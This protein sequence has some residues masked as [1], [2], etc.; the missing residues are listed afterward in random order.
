MVVKCGAIV[1]VDVALVIVV[2]VAVV[3]VVTVD[4]KLFGKVFGQPKKISCAE[5]VD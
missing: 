5:N 4:V 3:V 1:V 2:D